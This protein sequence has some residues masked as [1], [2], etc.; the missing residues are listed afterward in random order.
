MMFRTAF[1]TL[2][3]A[4]LAIASAAAQ[5]DLARW[6][7]DPLRELEKLPIAAAVADGEPVVV[8]DGK[9]GVEGADVYVVDLG[10]VTES[11][12]AFLRAHFLGDSMCVFAARHGVRYRT[13]TDGEVRVAMPARGLAVAIMGEQL[14]TGVSAAGRVNVMLEQRRLVRIEVVHA[15]GRPAP[16][17]MICGYETFR[18]GRSGAACT[19]FAGRARLHVRYVR[20]L[21]I[22]A[23]ITANEVAEVEV[24]EDYFEARPALLRLRLP[25]LGSVLAR[26]V[27]RDDCVAELEID[28]G[29]AR[30]TGRDR[31]AVA[32]AR[33]TEEGAFFEHVAVGTEVVVTV[34]CAGTN[35][36]TFSVPSDGPSRPE[37][38]VAVDCGPD[39]LAKDQRYVTARVLDGQGRPVCEQEV[40]TC[41]LHAGG[42]LVRKV[43]T[44]TSGRLSRSIPGAGFSGEPRFLVAEK[45]LGNWGDV[46]VAVAELELGGSG[47]VELGDLQMTIAPVFASGRVVDGDG[48]PVTGV[49]VNL[50]EAQVF[51]RRFS[52]PS[53]HSRTDDD[54]RFELRLVDYLPVAH[55]V[56]VDEK[57][58]LC[59][60]VAVEPGDTGIELQ[61]VR[62]G[63]LVVDFGERRRPPW[64]DVEIVPAAGGK[65][66]RAYDIAGSVEFDDVRPGR[67]GVR[68]SV[69]DHVLSGIEGLDVE[70]GARCED[71]R[72]T[73]DWRTLVPLLDVSLLD[74]GGLP[75]RGRVRLSSAVHTEGSRV[76]QCDGHGHAQV[77]FVDGLQFLAEGEDHRTVAFRPSFDP[78]VVRMRPRARLRFVVPDGLQ[79]PVG[80][81][82]SEDGGVNS[83]PIGRDGS[84]RPAGS[85]LVTLSFLMRPQFGKPETL[86]RQVVDVPNGNGVMDIPL[87]IDADIA[88]RAEAIAARRVNVPWRGR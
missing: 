57:G 31:A 61:A 39:L 22:R 80:I 50:A 10:A 19:D 32:P 71:P 14:G 17:V 72:L 88:D 38:A 40:W 79:L 64:L 58:W 37:D 81:Q 45:S 9:G 21:R 35:A 67:Y 6:P 53:W 4:G 2:V 52:R 85:G 12:L 69:L 34:R 76:I 62:S 18:R 42:R 11:T 5:R 55:D 7:A 74:E 25:A 15:D 49:T 87:E 60:E 16:G 73:I 44:D 41:F 23:M 66:R 82:V 33:Y 27:I 36:M 3:A 47:D 51:G 20:G 65:P 30:T 78:T 56:K 28:D 26:G 24:P 54:G 68:L 29:K 70:P 86:W 43:R 77:P 84:W 8:R 83:D 59:D 75:I 1:A 63:R 13:G 46:P 48:R